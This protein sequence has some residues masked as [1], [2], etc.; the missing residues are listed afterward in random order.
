MDIIYNIISRLNWLYVPLVTEFNSDLR[1]IFRR[2]TVN[3]VIGEIRTG[4][5]R[6]DGDAIGAIFSQPI[7]VVAIKCLVI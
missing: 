1:T 5:V 7:D 3:D 2:R 6:V 4:S